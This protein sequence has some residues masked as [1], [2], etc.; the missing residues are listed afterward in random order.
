VQGLKSAKEI[1]DVLKTAHEG[2]EVT[3]ITKHETIKGEL[4]R[5]VLNK[6]EE[7]QAM[8]NRLKTMV[9]EVRN[10][11]STKW[12]DHEMVK[13]I[14][15]SLVFRNPTQVQLI[16]GDPRY[17][18]MSPKEVIGKFV[19]FELMIKDSKHIVNLEQCATSTPEVQPVAFKATEEEK[20]STS[21]R[22]PIDASKLNNEEMELIIKSFRQILKQRRGKNYKSRSKRVCYRCGKYGHF[23]AKCP[24]SSESDRDEDKKGK[25]KEKKKYYKKKGGDAHICREWDFDKSST[26]SSSDEDAANIAVNKGLLFPNVDHKCLM[27]KDSKKKKVLSRSTPKY[28]TSSDEGSSSDNEDDLLSLFTNLNMEQK[29]KLNE[30][31]ETINEKDDL[32]E[33]QDDFLVKENKK[34]VKLK[35]AYTQEIEKCENLSKGLSICHDSISSLRTENASLVSKIEKFNVCNDSISSLRIENDKL[36]A[37][38]EELNACKPST[39][40][41]DHV[42]ICTRCRDLNIEAMDDHLAIIKQQND[43]IAKLTA[44]ITEHELEMKC[45]NLLEACSI[46]GDALALRM[47]LVSNR[48]IKT[49]PSLMPLKKYL[50][51]LRARLPW[52]RIVRVTFYILQTISNIRLGRFMLGNLFLFL[53]MHLCIKMR[54]LALGIPLIKM[55]KT[56]ISAASNVHNISFK[57]FDSSYVLT[58]KSGKIV[59]KYVGGKHKSLKTC[60]WVPKV[61]VYSMKGPKTIWVPKNKT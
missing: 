17:K 13:V 57:T 56:K 21:S 7:P 20:E 24:I 59:A 58:N 11:G 54:L 37:K 8:Y 1:W 10:L 19:S 29:K 60:V 41:V 27:A 3:K 12:D 43:H 30:L 38:I 18:L 42:T 35:N 15:R 28:T 23:I 50:S 22:L 51:L 25:K 53:I 45:L 46:I 31:I 39:S 48:G 52:F 16:R 5:F 47:V 4:G 6:G 33:S 44:K 32:L 36:N 40:T 2:D 9:N 61:L 55:P 34:I 26:D 14:R 49:T